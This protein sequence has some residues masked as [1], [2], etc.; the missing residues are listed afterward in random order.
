MIFTASAALMP[1]CRVQ[2]AGEKG[3]IT[4]LLE[5]KE[6]MRETE[7]EKEEKGEINLTFFDLPEIWYNV[8]IHLKRWVS[9]IMVFNII[10]GIV[11]REA[12]QKVMEFK[13]FGTKWM[14]W[15]SLIPFIAV[16]VYCGLYGFFNL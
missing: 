4:T 12:G 9:V 7:R 5:E 6:K 3:V 14:L 2:A 11:I 15:G 16:N 8:G 13:K 10:L 1:A